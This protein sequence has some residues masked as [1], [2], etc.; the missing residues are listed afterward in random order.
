MPKIKWQPLAMDD[1]RHLR[2]YIK[3][4]NPAAA[5]RVAERIR[6]LVRRLA[7]MPQM[8]RPGRIESTRE[9]VVPD[10][11]YIVVYYVDGDTVNIISVIHG[12]REWPEQL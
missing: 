4:D 7:T 12:A 6:A 2:A 9:L 1:L 5:K 8:G 3:Q 11:P 10:T